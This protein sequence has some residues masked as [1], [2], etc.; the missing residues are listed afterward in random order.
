YLQFIYMRNAYHFYSPQPGPAS[1]L[2]FLLKTETGIDPQTNKPTYDTHWVVLPKRPADLKD[3]LGLTYYRYLAVTEQVARA[4]PALR[5][6]TFEAEE[7][8]KRR[9]LAF[10]QIPRHPVDELDY[11]YQLLQ[12]EIARYIVPSYASHV[13]LEN[14]PNKDVAAK[15]TVK[16]YRVQHNTLG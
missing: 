3:P 1:V 4:T 16:M 8:R 6:N 2:V 9:Q 15:T 7:M 5:S 14:T 10:L 12:P 11:Q 13:I